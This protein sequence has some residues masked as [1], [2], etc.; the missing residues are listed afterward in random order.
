MNR[1]RKITAGLL[2]CAAAAAPAQVSSQ[3]DSLF[4]RG[5]DA[6][7]ETRYQEAL[8]TLRSLD[9]VYPEHQ[10]TTASLLLQGKALY[11]LKRYEPAGEAFTLLISRFPESRY[12][13]DAR[14]GLACVHYRRNRFREAVLQLIAIRETEGEGKLAQRSGRLSSG[15]AFN[16][17]TADELKALLRE[18]TTENSK[19]AITVELAR[20]RLEDH[21]ATESRQLLEDFLRLHPRNAYAGEMNQLLG[22][23][24]R[25]GKGVQ[26][27]GVILPLT[28]ALAEQGKS[29]LSGISFAVGQHNEKGT[30]KFELVVR[31]SEGRMLPA[32]KAAQELCKNE[33]VVAVIG[34]LES[35]TTLAAAAVAQENDVPFLAPSA[36]EDGIASIGPCVF[37]L[38]G[39]LATRVE[40]LADYAVTALGLKR[41]AVLYPADD[42][43]QRMQRAFSDQI[44]RRR[45][46]M[47]AEK[48][49]Y[50]NAEDLAPQFRAI[51][52][53]G[54]KQMIQDTVLIPENA[55][56][57][58]TP[59]YVDR[60]TRELAD[61]TSIEVNSIDGFFLPVY[62]SNMDIVLAQLAY[63]TFQTQVL[64][65]TSW[66]DLDV[67]KSH[68]A[69]DGA[70]FFSD[71][72]TDAYSPRFNEFRNAYRRAKNLDP[73]KWDVL[74]ADAALF[75]IDAAGSVPLTRGELRQKLAGMASF[76]GL[77]GRMTMDKNRVNTSVTLLQ[78]KE[79]R[80]FKI[81]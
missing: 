9:R 41:F 20:Q 30:I 71:F 60:M 70:V 53:A 15:I 46:K 25:L 51:R 19:A 11:K 22:R 36:M 7:K 16:R 45:G 76:D 39:S 12:A 67:L 31:D 3:V 57:R 63:Q 56:R 38:N 55:P 65:G 68:Q 29:V 40:K 44:A 48:W 17:M 78:Y 32:V 72:Y 26:K 59:A 27:I 24:E 43:G 73:G 18:L 28:G 47:L 2:L 81:Q 6:Y 69:A 79:G 52:E 37:Q 62:K 33:D 75:L 49:Y 34:D 1:I 74:G 21:D 58:M 10:R 66:D 42:Y 64:G 4:Y 35:T 54:L 50:E 77:H 23:A 14:Y 8:G 5:V 61:S 80:I 13:G